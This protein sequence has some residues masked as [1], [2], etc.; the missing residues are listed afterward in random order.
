MDIDL[1]RAGWKMVELVSLQRRGCYFLRHGVYLLLEAGKGSEAR[2]FE[3]KARNKQNEICET[4]II[5]VRSKIHERTRNLFNSN[6]ICIF[7]TF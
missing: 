5:P 4:E 1:L 3:G 2:R 7:L 6:K